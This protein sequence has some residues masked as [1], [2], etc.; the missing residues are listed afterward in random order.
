MLT[1]GLTVHCLVSLG[2]SRTSGLRVCVCVC[3]CAGGRELGEREMYCNRAVGD[4]QL[5][6]VVCRQLRVSLHLKESSMLPSRWEQ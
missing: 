5:V 2:D 6:R 1:R 3:V 4:C